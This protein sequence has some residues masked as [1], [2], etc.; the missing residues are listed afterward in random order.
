MSEPS[1]GDLGMLRVW[2]ELLFDGAKERWP[3]LTR[4]QF[5]KAVEHVWEGKSELSITEMDELL[6]HEL[7]KL[8]A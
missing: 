3:K 5:D 1:L 2:T 4:E 7:E 8:F 6:V